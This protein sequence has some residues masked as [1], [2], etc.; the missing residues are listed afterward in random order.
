MLKRAILVGLFL[1]LS[2][3]VFAQSA[4]VSLTLTGPTTILSGTSPAYNA[5]F[6]NAG[7]DP[8]ATV[9]LSLRATAYSGNIFITNFRTT[10]VPAGMTCAPAFDTPQGPTILCTAPSVAAAASGSVIATFDASGTGGQFGIDARLTTI[11]NDPNPANNNASLS[12]VM[13]VPNADLTASLATPATSPVASGSTLTFTGSFRNDGPDAATN[14]QFAMVFTSLSGTVLPSN[15]QV[16]SV[17]AGFT[18][19]APVATPQGPRVVCTN[20]SFASGA[21]G[22]I[23][24][25]VQLTGTGNFETCATFVSSTFDPDT[26]GLPNAGCA[27]FT[28]EPAAVPTT[29][30]LSCPGTFLGGTSANAT[31]TL[32]QAQLTPTTIT[33]MSATPGVA[34]VP[35]TVV[36]PANQTSATFAILGVTAGTSIITAT[37]PVGLGTAQTCTATVVVEPSTHEAENV[38]TL[39]EWA[40]IA[41]GLGLAFVATRRIL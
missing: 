11:T 33:L 5:T 28:V 17:Q 6:S 37:P 41:L 2:S 21:T 35:A 29:S 12:G 3:A 15:I 10:S 4:D 36:I 26:N 38:P 40:L 7:P 25:S 14:A 9:E 23:A 19:A 8:A 13:V 20:P 24:M 27:T 30:S 31:V 32:S 16:T 39:G 22:Q 1:T 34:T 18:C